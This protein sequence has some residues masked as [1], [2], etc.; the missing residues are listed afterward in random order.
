MYNFNLKIYKF[1]KI[2]AKSSSEFNLNLMLVN[3]L[4]ALLKSQGLSLLFRSF[5]LNI[6]G[7][8]IYQIFN[9]SYTLCKPTRGY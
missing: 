3:K 2:N 4:Q 5:N 9:H 1:V 7:R 8:K 6:V